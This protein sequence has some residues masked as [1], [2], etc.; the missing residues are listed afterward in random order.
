VTLAYIMPVALI[1]GVN[2]QDGSYLAE[3][4][5]L[6]EY[7]VVGTTLDRNTD[8]E[9]ISHIREKIEIVETDLLDQVQVEDILRKYR[10]DEVY[11]FA[12]RASSREL[13]TQPVLTGE[14]NALAVTRLLDAIRISGR[15]VRF[16][17]ASSS[18]VFGNATE[19]PQSET[20]PFRPRNPYGVAKAYGHWTTVIY[21]E[22]CG[23]FACSS[24]LYNHESPRRGL[25]FITRKVSNT[26]ARIKLGQAH[27]LR[28]GNLDAQR[29][30]GFAGD[31]VQAMWLI[32]QQPTP[33]DYVVAT[34]QAHSV[35]E[36]CETAFSHV[37][38]DYQDYVVQDSENFRSADTALLVGNP[39]KAKRL[40]GWEPR[41]TFPELVHMMVDG[42]LRLIQNSDEQLTSIT[43]R[44]C[45]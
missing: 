10:P 32:L 45:K 24:I 16:V 27:E 6:K 19:A 4:L 25:E 23:L 38:L 12:A 41:I 5:L 9:R 29:D 17:Q 30:W 8:Q 20:T 21:R 2:G 3:F 40:L 13:W 14:L 22:H 42:D 44:I 39:A 18:E 37:G 15:E 34:G 1:T 33:E 7:R 26:V 35:R 36:L 11:N 31:Y 28:L 43:G